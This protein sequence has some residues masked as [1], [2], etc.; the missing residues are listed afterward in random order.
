MGTSNAGWRAMGWTGLAMLGFV[1]A[2]F[3]YSTNTSFKNSLISEA[4]AADRHTADLEVSVEI[5][6]CET[7]SNQK[8]RDELK[9][10]IESW[11]YSHKHCLPRKIDCREGPGESASVAIYYSSID[12]YNELTVGIYWTSFIPFY[13]KQS[14]SDAHAPINSWLMNLQQGET[15]E[16]LLDRLNTRNDCLLFVAIAIK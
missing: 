11:L 10:A 2:A 8:E 7:I 13:E 6:V 12:T 16:L 9:E 5:F 4:S 14:R 15:S 1:V 3:V